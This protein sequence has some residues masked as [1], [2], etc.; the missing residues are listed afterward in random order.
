MKH[1][2]TEDKSIQVSQLNPRKVYSCNKRI[3]NVDSLTCISKL[4][5]QDLAEIS[6]KIK[7]KISRNLLNL[8]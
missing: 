4:K 8:S 5:L 3:N 7:S 2:V 6:V 1:G